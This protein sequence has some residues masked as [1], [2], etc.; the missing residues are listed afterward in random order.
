M[1]LHVSA[2]DELD[3]GLEGRAGKGGPVQGS[4]SGFISVPKTSSMMVWEG[5]RK[6]AGDEVVGAS[7]TAWPYYRHHVMHE[8]YN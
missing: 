4:G 7:G 5:R 8:A 1:T 3:D 6:E 2:Q